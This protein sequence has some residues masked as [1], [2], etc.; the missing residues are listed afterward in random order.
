M[1][2]RF[3]EEKKIIFIVIIVLFIIVSIAMGVAMSNPKGNV[4]EEE[5]KS[6]SNQVGD[7]AYNGTGLIE[8]KEDD[9][10]VENR[11]DASGTWEESNESESEEREAGSENMS[12]INGEEAGS[13]NMSD[14]NEEEADSGNALD[15]IQPNDSDK[16]TGEDILTDSDKKT[17]GDIY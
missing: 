8:N 16:V 10:T 3:I 1:V 13:E 17:W 11:T 6:N 5:Q 4:K 12:D 14:I 9:G 15:D 7:E 2:K